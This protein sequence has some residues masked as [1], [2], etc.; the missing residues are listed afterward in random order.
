MELRN[1]V[2]DRLTAV[3]EKQTEW[4]QEEQVARMRAIS[5]YKEAPWC[6]VPEA[7]QILDKSPIT[8]QR[9]R[10]Q[11]TGPEWSYNGNKVVYRRADLYA[12]PL[13]ELEQKQDESAPASPPS[14]PD[15]TE[16]KWWEASQ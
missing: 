5:E 15:T 16:N 7:S 6:Y 8:L 13:R 12:W 4:S 14:Q 11:G 3:E 1:E 2:E 10:S 9:W